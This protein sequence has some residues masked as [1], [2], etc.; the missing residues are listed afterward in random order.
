MLRE[1]GNKGVKRRSGR[2]DSKREAI[3]ESQRMAGEC[4]NCSSSGLLL[5][6]RSLWRRT[7]MHGSP[8]AH[9]NML[10]PPGRDE[11]KGLK[12]GG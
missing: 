10:P 8:K 6:T 12:E 1:M 11:K 4:H 2:S 3:A 9:H 5:H 7:H